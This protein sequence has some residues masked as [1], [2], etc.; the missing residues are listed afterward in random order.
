MIGSYWPAAPVRKP[1]QWS[2]PHPVRPVVERARRAHLAARRHVPLAEP[3]GDVAVLLED[4]REGGAAARARPGVAGERAGELG[5]GAHADAVVVAAGQHRGPRRRADGGDV[6]PVVGE[7]HLPHAGEVRGRDAAAEGVGAAEAGVVDEDEQHVGRV[8][9][10]LGSGDEGPVRRRVGDR[11]AGGAAEGL[12]RDRQH[13]AV[14]GELARRLG[15]RV[16][17]PAQAVLVHRGDRLGRRAGERLLGDEPV[18]L[19]DDGDDRRR[20]RLELVAQAGLE[21]AVDLVLGELADDA[22]GGRADGRRGQQRRRGQA[23]QDAHA[24][25][26]AHALAAEVVAGLRDADLAALVVLDEDD[27]LALDLLVL[28]ELHQP[29]EVLLGRLDALIAGHDDRERV[30][31][32]SLPGP[33][34]ESGRRCRRGGALYEPAATADEAA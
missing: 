2:K 6:E 13:G 31:H 3:A 1:H 32:W 5:D 33:L 26:P 34:G 27:A 17:Q 7:P 16:L 25:A 11:P 19:R 14:G 29:I 18:G 20:A 9:R 8:F 24:A 23:D 28:D 22:A 4:A 21:A 30:A 12:V 10:R 15:E